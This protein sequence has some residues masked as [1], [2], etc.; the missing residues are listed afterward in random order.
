MS[1]RQKAINFSS[2]QRFKYHEDKRHDEP[3]PQPYR[4]G[5]LHVKP[6]EAQVKLE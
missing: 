1:G 5:K 6:G 3:K 4:R 2:S